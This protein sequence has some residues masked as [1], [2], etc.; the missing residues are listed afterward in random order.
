M[1]QIAGTLWAPVR[2]LGE[3]SIHETAIFNAASNQADHVEGIDDTFVSAIVPGL[4][5]EFY[6][7]TASR[8]RC[9]RSRAP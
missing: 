2:T 9:I 4:C 8:N 7:A 5:P 6:R 1:L 3:Y